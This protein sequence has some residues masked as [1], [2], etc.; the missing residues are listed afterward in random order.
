M[1]GDA[2][3]CLYMGKCIGFEGL[4]DEWAFWEREYTRRGFITISMDDFTAAG[5]Y[6]KPITHLLFKR[7]DVDEEPILHAERY[8]ERYFHRMPH[9]ALE[10][11]FGAFYDSAGRPHLIFGNIPT[12]TTKDL[13]NR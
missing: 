4:F 7:R 2:I 3:S 12:P 8:R 9:G 13:P 5:G 1:F 10:G 11:G 6:G